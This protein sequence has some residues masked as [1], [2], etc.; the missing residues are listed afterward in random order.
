MSELFHLFV[1]LCLLSFRFYHEFRIYAKAIATRQTKFANTS[2]IE[3]GTESSVAVQ[4]GTLIYLSKREHASR[5]A[6]FSLT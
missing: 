3:V 2:V 1:I 6:H 5:D 4:S